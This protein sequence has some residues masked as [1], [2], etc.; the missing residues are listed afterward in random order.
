MP[1]FITP[2]S[3]NKA[4]TFWVLSRLLF[5]VGVLLAVFAGK[6]TYGMRNSA[7]LL[8]VSAVTSAF[9][10]YLVVVYL[11]YLPPMYEPLVK[12]QTPLKIIIEYVVIGEGV[13]KVKHSH[14]AEGRGKNEDA[15]FLPVLVIIP[16]HKTYGKRYDYA[17]NLKDQ[18]QR[19]VNVIGNNKIEFNREKIQDYNDGHYQ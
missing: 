12:S 11:P 9:V 8:V 17:G 3:V 4:S 7:L 6:K 2:N 15:Q 18:V 14:H 19:C 10:I 1:D 13:G 16:A 5:G